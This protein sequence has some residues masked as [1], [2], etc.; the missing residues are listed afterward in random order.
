[1]NVVIHVHP[2]GIVLFF[3]V[4]NHFLTQ[5]NFRNCEISFSAKFPSKLWRRR[6]NCF[7]FQKW[8]ICIVIRSYVTN[9]ISDRD[10]KLDQCQ[11]VYYFLLNNIFESNDWGIIWCFSPP[12][13]AEFS[14]PIICIDNARLGISFEFY[15]FNEVLVVQLWALV[16]T[17][18]P[19]ID[20]FILI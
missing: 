13:L 5:M 17:F 12:L 15:L 16:W 6:Q 1:M 19:F 10:F 11:S 9:F 2:C 20:L 8:I 14:R 3:F 7:S 4:A 18:H